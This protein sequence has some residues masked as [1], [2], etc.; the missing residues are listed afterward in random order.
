MF[1]IHNISDEEAALVEPT[2]CAIHGM[3][4]LEPKVGIDAL[5]LGAG[6]SG[7]VF[8]QLLQLN[9]AARVVIAAN[10]GKK[11]EIARDLNAADEYVELDR[12]D[13]RAQWDALRRDNPYGFD[14]VVSVLDGSRAEAA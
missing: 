1:K 12:E 8:A 9:G 10:K 3:E 6:P 11:T 13:P 7:L 4:R 5:V 2:S 14:V